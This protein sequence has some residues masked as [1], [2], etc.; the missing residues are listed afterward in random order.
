VFGLFSRLFEIDL[1]RSPNC[2][3]EMKIM[4]AILEAPVIER[5]LTHL[6]L[7]ARGFL[8]RANA[9]WICGFTH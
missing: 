9:P 6:A 8:R 2:G 5:I 7:L 4:A 1:E 3:S